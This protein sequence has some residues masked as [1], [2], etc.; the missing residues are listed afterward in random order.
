MTCCLNS[1]FETQSNK[2]KGMQSCL[3]VKSKSLKKLQN[4]HLLL[5]NMILPK[6]LKILTPRKRLWYKII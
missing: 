5:H 3:Q 4:G 6:A 1:I 2:L